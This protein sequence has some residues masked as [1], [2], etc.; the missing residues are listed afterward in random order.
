MRRITFNL[1]ERAT[2]IPVEIAAA[3]KPAVGGI[4]SVML[5]AL[6]LGIAGPAPIKTVWQT[7]L[8][9]GAAVGIGLFSGAVGT[10]ILLPW[11]PGKAFALKGA[12]LGLA[13]AVISQLALYP[14]MDPETGV[15]LTL[16]TIAASS[17]LAMN[18]TGAT[19]FTSPSGV[20]KEMRWA[21]PAQALVITI[22]MI[23][24][25]KAIWIG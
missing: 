3:F 25:F 5:I 21:I 17:F 12:G 6:L 7:M 22:G 16:L 13:A 15:A 23:G 2:L 8:L 18:F 24:W 10:P 4:G 20:E 11:L 9:G 1:R 14:A 19:P